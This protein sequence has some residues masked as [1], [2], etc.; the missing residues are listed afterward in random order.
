MSLHVILNVSCADMGANK[1]VC[2]CVCV[3][4]SFPSL[5]KWLFVD[6]PLLRMFWSHVLPPASVPSST[7]INSGLEFS[8]LFGTWLL[9]LPSFWTYVLTNWIK[10]LLLLAG[11]CNSHGRPAFYKPSH[12]RRDLFSS[13][14]VKPGGVPKS[15][16]GAGG[17]PVPD[18][19][20]KKSNLFT[21][22]F[23]SLF[24][25]VFSSESFCLSSF[26]FLSTLI[27]SICSA[28]P[29]PALKTQRWLFKSPRCARFQSIIGF[30]WEKKMYVRA[31][32]WSMKNR[33][34]G[35]RALRPGCVAPT[36]F[37]YWLKLLDV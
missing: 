12:T 35:K 16:R 15:H 34:W 8:L 30:N 11:S 3:S 9:L 26:I 32:A 1:P 14:C 21:D 36:L 22:F 6:L 29:G 13:L 2:V 31:K 24:L 5:Q 28:W 33:G 25:T 10:H 37:S 23:F 4:S 7:N 17:T 27:Y 18:P 20:C 19:D